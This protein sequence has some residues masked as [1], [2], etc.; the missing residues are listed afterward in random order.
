MYVCTYVVC[1]CLYIWCVWYHVF[2]HRA[3]QKC[4]LL[5]SGLH[6]LCF[7]TGEFK[8]KLRSKL[9]REK[10]ASKHQR[11]HKGSSVALSTNETMGSLTAGQY[12]IIMCIFRAR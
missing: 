11:F 9:E 12:S 3:L 5:A 10:Q 2:S 6:W 7:K 8:N 1:L 4:N